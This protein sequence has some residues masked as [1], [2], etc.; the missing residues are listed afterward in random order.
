M[1]VY[2][3][4]CGKIDTL[5][6]SVEEVGAASLDGCMGILALDLRN[7]GGEELCEVTVPTLVS[8]SSLLIV[9]PHFVLN[10]GDSLILN[11][12]RFLLFPLPPLPPFSPSDSVPCFGMF[13]F[14]MI[15]DWLNRFHCKE[16]K[17][18][19]NS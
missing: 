3:M 8:W 19:A 14:G 2:F 6:I 17:S 9:I 11:M 7:S 1:Y 12:L 18:F 10:H 15:P 5:A 13:W 16:R 4:D